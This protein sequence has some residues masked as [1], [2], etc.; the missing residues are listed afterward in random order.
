MR[1]VYNIIYKINL[2]GVDLMAGLLLIAIWL[3][4]IIGLILLIMGAI[5]YDT[6]II[7]LSTICFSISILMSVIGMIIY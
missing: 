5:K 3:V 6:G 7:S 4:F 1:S 2:K